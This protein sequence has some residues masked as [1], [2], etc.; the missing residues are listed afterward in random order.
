MSF[1][2]RYIKAPKDEI[3]EAQQQQLATQKRHRAE[4]EAFGIYA[5]AGGSQFTYR[6]R[7]AGAHGG[8]TIMTEKTEKEMTR[9]ELLDMRAKKKADRHCY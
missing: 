9:E 8:Y 4:Q 2:F 7:K 5:S 1:I 3:D 6:V